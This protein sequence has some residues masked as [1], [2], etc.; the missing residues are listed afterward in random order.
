MKQN[1]IYTIKYGKIVK[2]Y[3]NYEKLMEL[4]K[5]NGYYFSFTEVKKESLKINFKKKQYDPNIHKCNI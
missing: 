2:V 4:G 5:Q 3:G 1:F